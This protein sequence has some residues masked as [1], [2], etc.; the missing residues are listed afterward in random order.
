MIQY[1]INTCRAILVDI[2]CPSIPPG[3]LMVAVGRSA[4]AVLMA[5]NFL[6]NI[7]NRLP[8]GASSSTIH[9]GLRDTPTDQVMRVTILMSLTKQG[10]YVA[11]RELS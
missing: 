10:D 11:V 8:M 1:L 2:S 5:S 9:I 4:W 3:D 6:S 7:P